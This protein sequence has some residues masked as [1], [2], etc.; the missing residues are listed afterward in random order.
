MLYNIQNNTYHIRILSVCI[1][2]TD[3]KNSSQNLGRRRRSPLRD[4]LVVKVRFGLI[5]QEEPYCF[6]PDNIE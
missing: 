2:R 5:K 4:A 6:L 3:N 1:N